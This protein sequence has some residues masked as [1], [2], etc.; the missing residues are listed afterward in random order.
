[1]Q[2]KWQEL[3]LFKYFS[4]QWALRHNRPQYLTLQL[5]TPLPTC[6]PGQPDVR[7]KEFNL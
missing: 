2:G 4:A 3:S 1:M 6:T 7:M 5:Q